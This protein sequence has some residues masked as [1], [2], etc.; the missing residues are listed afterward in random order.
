MKI[1][2]DPMQKT[3][4]YIF[5]ILLLILYTSCKPNRLNVDISGIADET[6]IVRFDRE[7]FQFS[8]SSPDFPDAI[9][10]LR[11]KYPDFFDLYTYQMIRIG[12]ISD[13]LFIE[14][15]TLFL[16]DTTIQNVAKLAEQSFDDFADIKMKMGTAFR[17]FRYHFPEMEIP[18]IYT[19][20]SGFNQSIVIA[21]NLIGI[22]LEKY[23]GPDCRY[24]NMLAIPKYKQQKMIPERLPVDM[25][26]GWA[27]SEFV[28]SSHESNLLSFMIYEGKLLYFIDAMFP[29][30]QD[31]LKIGYTAKQLDWCQRNEAQMWTTLVENRMLYTS[32]RMDIRRIIDDSPY[33]NGFPAESPGRAGAWIGWQIIREYM[34]KNPG[35]S[36]KQLFDLDD[37]QKILNDSKYYPLR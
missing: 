37:S 23:M 29:K 20:I 28:K 4:L 8:P 16:N 6:G 34:E 33:T 24:Y 15:L 36:L 12:G 31:S 35:I 19:C 11:E 30:M 21:Q 2:F 5:I 18:R 3:G 1:K 9:F 32:Q 10:D 17:Y 26:Y 14:N 7:L 22:S 25:M 13:S 27:K